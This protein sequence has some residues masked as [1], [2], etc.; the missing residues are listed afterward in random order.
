MKDARGTTWLRLCKSALVLPG[1][2]EGTS[3]ATPALHVGKKLLARLTEDGETVAVRVELLDR[4]VLLEADPRAFFVTDHYLAYPFIL[5]RLNAARHGAVVEL[6]EHAWQRAAPKR[7]VAEHLA[8]SARSV[9]Q[10][11]EPARE[12]RRRRTR[13]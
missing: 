7:V 8:R 11:E 3:Y 13:G 6:I 5:V 10:N 2:V 9:G 1:V 12:P 4:D